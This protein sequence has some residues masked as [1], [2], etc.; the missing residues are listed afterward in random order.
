MQKAFE[1]YIQIYIQSLHY[2]LLYLSKTFF[3]YILSTLFKFRKKS[4]NNF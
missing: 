3:L 1:I 2:Y 4:E